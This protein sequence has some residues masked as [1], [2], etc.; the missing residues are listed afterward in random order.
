MAYFPPNKQTYANVTIANGG[1]TIGNITGTSGAS[2]TYSTG[3]SASPIW[4]TTATATS[5]YHKQ[6]KVKISEDDIEIDGLS[7]K[8]TLRTM[9][10]RLAIMV[11]NPEL[12]REFEE[13]RAC[14][15]EYRRLEREFTEQ[16]RVWNTLKTTDNK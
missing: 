3:T 1:Y 6:P 8:A 11:P 13:L 9:H 10:E 7:L 16:L 2:L 5:Y 15:D 4:T 12:E 14:G